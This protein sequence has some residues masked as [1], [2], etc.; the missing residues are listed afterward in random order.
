MLDFYDYYGS[1]TPPSVNGT[2]VITMQTPAN[3]PNMA[4]NNLVGEYGCFN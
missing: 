3:Y 2:S 4:P 1:P